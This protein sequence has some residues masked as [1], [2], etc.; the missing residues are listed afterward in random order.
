MHL[1]NFQNGS[2]SDSCWHFL[3]V[4]LWNACLQMQQQNNFFFLESENF[5]LSNFHLGCPYQ[6]F[7]WFTSTIL[8]LFYLQLE[9]M[10]VKMDYVTE[11]LPQ[12]FLSLPFFHSNKLHQWLSRTQCSRNKLIRDFLFEQRSF[13]TFC[14]LENWGFVTR[15]PNWK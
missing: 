13:L 7:I 1:N 12:V 9:Q 15:K 8:H 11:L 14:V 2:Y 6:V 5:L 10:T 4:L 3:V